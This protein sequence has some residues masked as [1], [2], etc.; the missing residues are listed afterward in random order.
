MGPPMSRRLDSY[1][2]ILDA[3]RFAA[4]RPLLNRRDWQPGDRS[5]RWASG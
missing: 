3:R 5:P 2:L 1:L 4:R